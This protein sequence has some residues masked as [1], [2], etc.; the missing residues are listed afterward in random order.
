M[1]LYAVI[2]AAQAAAHP[3]I[4]EGCV[5]SEPERCRRSADGQILIEWDPRLGKSKP[6]G[7]GPVLVM[8]Q[9][10]AAELMQ[11]APWSEEIEE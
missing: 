7:L 9:A 1:S 4:F 6:A 5:S 10:E 11:A 3:E 2:T 8:T